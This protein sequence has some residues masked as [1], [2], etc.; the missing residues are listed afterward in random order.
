MN[1]SRFKRLASSTP[2][3]SNQYIMGYYGD[4]RKESSDVEEVFVTGEE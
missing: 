1:D 4:G 2:M 3:K